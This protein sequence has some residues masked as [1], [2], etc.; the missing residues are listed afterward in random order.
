MIERYNEWQKARQESD[1]RVGIVFLVV[2]SSLVAALTWAQGCI[3]ASFIIYYFTLIFSFVLLF[4]FLISK[5]KINKHS[6]VSS[7]RYT[8]GFFGATLNTVPI[9][10]LNSGYICGALMILITSLYAGF[11]AGV[12]VAL[13]PDKF[14]PSPVELKSFDF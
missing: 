7:S 13:I 9:C 12:I 1:R 10:L 5:N 8:G 11:S 4:L 14:L 3:S 2:F 6:I